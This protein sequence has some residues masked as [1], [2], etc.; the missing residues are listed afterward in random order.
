MTVSNLSAEVL[1]GGGGVGG[2]GGGTVGQR[3]RISWQASE[4]III[5]GTC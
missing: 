5:S 3:V 1:D 2:V 4:T